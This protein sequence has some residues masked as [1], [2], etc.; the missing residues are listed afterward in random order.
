MV[1]PINTGFLTDTTASRFAGQQL[2]EGLGALGK[3]IATGMLRREEQERLKKE[4]KAKEDQQKIENDFKKAKQ[5]ADSKNNILKSLITPDM[6]LDQ[7]I[8]VTQ[9]VYPDYYKSVSGVVSEIAKDASNQDEITMNVL[10]DVSDMLEKGTITSPIQLQNVISKKIKEFGGR[11]LKKGEK[12]AIKQEMFALTAQQKGEG[13]SIGRAQAE[14]KKPMTTAQRKNYVK[15]DDLASPNYAN[16]GEIEQ[17]SRI[18]R[19]HHFELVSS[20]KSRSTRFGKM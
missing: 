16:Q 2:S 4:A 17:D 10:N 5:E 19:C 20:A 7:K 18:K 13:Y 15:V 6:P 12:E 1:Q 9:A 8:K 14:L 3:G 11:E